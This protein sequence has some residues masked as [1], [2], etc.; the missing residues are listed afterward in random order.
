MRDINSRAL[1]LSLSL[2]SL[3]YF[4]YNPRLARV[5]ASYRDT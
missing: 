3:I 5:R 4:P 1:S 2:P